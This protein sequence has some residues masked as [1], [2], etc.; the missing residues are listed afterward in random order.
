MECSVQMRS[1]TDAWHSFD[2]FSL[3][4]VSV[5]FPHCRHIPPDPSHSY[6]PIQPIISSIL[7]TG[8]MSQPLQLLVTDRMRLALKRIPESQLNEEQEK[9]YKAIKSILKK[10]VNTEKDQRQ[11]KEK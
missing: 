2:T 7:S 4:S 11:R 8:T 6:D 1:F 9:E 10:E 3:V 5:D